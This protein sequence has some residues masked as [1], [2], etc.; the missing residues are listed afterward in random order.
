MSKWVLV[1]VVVVVE[2]VVK[3]EYIVSWISVNEVNE[4]RGVIK[5]VRMTSG[6]FPVSAFSV[7]RRRWS[8]YWIGTYSLRFSS[9]V[10]EA[11]HTTAPPTLPSW[12]LLWS[13][14]GRRCRRLPLRYASNCG[15]CCDRFG[16]E[17][18]R[19]EAAVPQIPRPS[20]PQHFCNKIQVF[21]LLFL[22]DFNLDDAAAAAAAAAAE[23]EEEFG[24]TRSRCPFP[25]DPV[26]GLD[27]RRRLLS[28][29]CC[30]RIS[31]PTSRILKKK[32]KW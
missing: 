17:S 19:P 23:E 8:F 22:F 3:D 32:K 25:W 7:A 16:V 13:R 4:D 27:D 28:G 1:V 30:A 2:V 15:P 10:A 11:L 9:C 26:G 12:P 6:T 14:R 5:S 20:R 24:V 31:G 29:G 18:P 21:F